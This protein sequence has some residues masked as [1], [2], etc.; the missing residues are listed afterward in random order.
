MYIAIKENQK[1]YVAVTNRESLVDMS[2]KDMLLG[3]NLTLWKISGRKGW[4]IA[5]AR[6]NSA[7]DVLRYAKGLFTK[8]ITY[9]SLLS[10][11]IPKLK[12]LLGERRLVK[13]KYWYNEALI[14][15]GKKA[16]VIDGYFCLREVVGFDVGDARDDIIRGCLEFNKNLPV[17]ERICEAIH[18]VEEM[19]G[20]KHFPAVVFD[21]TAGK[22][23]VW[24]S[25]EDAL[26]KLQYGKRL[27]G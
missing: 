25:Y 1:T 9:Q 6:F 19:R 10:H 23:E 7:T 11:T 8:E 5:T 27:N 3:E 4:Y 14:V 18:S 12:Q 13:D 15:G 26:E 17:E 24:W 2:V 20:K 21:V 16:Y 22:K